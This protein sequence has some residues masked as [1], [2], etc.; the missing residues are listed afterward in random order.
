MR[1]CPAAAGALLIAL[2]ALPPLAFPVSAQ[3]QTITTDHFR[4]HFPNGASGTARRVAETAEEVFAPMASAYNYYDDYSTIHIVVLDNSDRL[5]NGSADYYTNTVFIWATN[6]D[7]ELRG[8][9]DWIRNVLTHELAHIMTLNKARKK[10]PFRWA[11][12]QVS[13]FDSNPDI[14]FNFPLYHLS[15]PDWW[16]EG[17]AQYATHQFGYDSWDSHRDMLLR[18]ATLEDDLLSYEEMGSL[19]SRSGGF[20][21]EWVYN[22]GYALLLYIHEQYGREKVEELTHH[23]GAMSF[24]PAIRRVLGVSADELYD[25][26][27]RFL[28]DH[29]QQMVVELRTDGL[30]EGRELKEVNEGLLEYFPSFSPDGRKVAFISSEDRDF[31]ITYLTIY[32]FDTGEA[33]TLSQ[34]YVDTRISW[35]PGGDEIVYV[36][37][38]D[39]FNDLYIYDFE[40]E[41]ERRISA[42]LRAK[43]PAFS[44]DGERIVFVHNE[45]GT[46]NLGLVNRDGSGVVR[47]TNH[48]DATQY[49]GPRF[50][51][52]GQWLLFTVFR[53]DDRDIA[54]MRADSP[55]LPKKSEAKGARKK[56]GVAADLPDSVEVFPDSLAFPDVEYSG[57]RPLL[58]SRSDERDA[59][60]LA[61]GSGFLFAS[62]QSGIFNIYRYHLESGEVERLTNVIGGAFAPT[63]S[64]EGK[65]VYAGYHSS[66]YSLYEFNLGD[67]ER[68]ARFQ[69]LA[70]R[71]YQSV[72]RGPKLAERYDIGRY[73]GRK[74]VNLLPLLNVGTTFVGDG[75]GLNQLSAGLQLQTGEQLGGSSM[76]AWGLFGKNFRADTDLNTDLG[77]FFERSLRPLVG[78]NR[79]FNPSFYVGYRRREVD[80][81]TST[82]ETTRDSIDWP[83]HELVSV[84]SSL[85]LMPNVR[86]WRLEE[87]GRKDKFKNIYQTITAG[88]DVPMSRRQRLTLQYQHRNYDG[89]WQLQQFRNRVEFLALQEVSPGDTVDI[90]AQLDDF[91]PIDTLLISPDDPL[92]FYSDL[93]F[94]S[95]HDLTALWV[96]QR[97]KPTAERRVNPTGR[98]VVA[99]YRYMLPTLADSL[100]TQT[101]PDGVPRDALGPAKRRLR[102]NEYLGLYEERIGLPFNNT[103][104]FR[105]MGGYR[106]LAVKTFDG[107]GGRFEGLFY[108]PLRY[109][110]GGLNQL[111]GY[112][113]F[114]RRGSKFLYGRVGYT[115]PLVQRLNASFLNFHFVNI[116]AELFGEAGAMG[117]FTKVEFNPGSTDHI[118]FKGLTKR[119]FLTD[120]GLELRMRLFTFYRIPMYSFFQI[121]HPL[122]RDREQARAKKQANEAALRRGQQ[123]DEDPPEKIDKYRL[124]F[125]LGF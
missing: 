94:Y 55:P 92:Q 79:T 53:G 32:N 87:I 113:Y 88:V 60:W 46:N 9:H 78:N 121:A 123:P 110:L 38:K 20:Y 52:D 86:L 101:S 116:Y 39:G 3:L 125:G 44:P 56:P 83:R 30:F 120:V 14:A 115:F 124:Y 90:T 65:V 18:M 36:R 47:L 17:V 69:P 24:D 54:I 33:S 105:V 118:L 23:S 6:L 95:S 112:P 22:Q 48:N 19:G 25:D 66:D 72:F 62:D 12:L 58:S 103:L 102:V 2:V 34:D 63:V 21:G 40:I 50:S 96:Y 74:V 70:L 71:D 57:Y 75:Y 42:N 81:V 41:R 93:D 28:D 82:S 104:S 16:S 4:I 122:N 59:A 51:P 107:E 85:M 73:G 108:W 10:W 106:N 27:R 31:A 77:I 13:R 5:G 26:W 76:T 98:T 15:T 8:S 45:D 84:D 100:A 67:Y 29:Y 97:I 109:N 117:N 99:L 43:D 7:F 64:P 1:Y 68:G 49:S 80:S 37:N 35:S 61:D 11:M 119:D 91:A 89:E 111:S 114:T